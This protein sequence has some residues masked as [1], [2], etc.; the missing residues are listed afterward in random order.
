MDTMINSKQIVQLR[1]KNA[2]SQEELAEISGLSH[3]TIQ[4]VENTGSCSPDSLKALASAFG[5][6][7]SE[8]YLDEKALAS[9]DSNRQ[10]AFYGYLGV[11]IGAASACLGITYSLVSGN[12]S[13]GHAGLYY[14]SI[15]AASGIFCAMIGTLSKKRSDSSSLAR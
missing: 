11:G 7:A 5:I 14:G 9:E 15:G 12:M 1:N 13:T 4:R 8:L 3:R 10:G 2:W 6:T